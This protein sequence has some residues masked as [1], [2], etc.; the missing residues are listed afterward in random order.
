MTRRPAAD[1]T[2]AL[3]VAAAAGFHSA[4]LRRRYGE[5]L[6]QLEESRKRI[7]R[8][9]DIERARIERDLHDGAQQRLIGLRIKLTLAEELVAAIPRRA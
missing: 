5:L 9:A 4:W 1:V 3:I 7:A 6:S 2:L 8:S